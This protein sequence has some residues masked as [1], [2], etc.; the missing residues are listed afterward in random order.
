MS[1]PWSITSLANFPSS[2][3]IVAPPLEE[4]DKLLDAAKAGRMKQIKQ[5]ASRIKQLDSKYVAFGDLLL[6]L[7]K[8][9]KEKA[10]LKLVEEQINAIKLTR[11][12]VQ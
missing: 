5:E 2:I 10:I 8:A 1:L 3:E 6:D 12:P 4:L 9:F 11:D 7:A